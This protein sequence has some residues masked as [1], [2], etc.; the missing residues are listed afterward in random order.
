LH[1]SRSAIVIAS[2][3]EET[4][5]TIISYYRTFT[6]SWNTSFTDHRRPSCLTT[7][8]FLPS[9]KYHPYASRR[10]YSPRQRHPYETIKS[11][12]YYT[13]PLR[14]GK[15]RSPTPHAPSRQPHQ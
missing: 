5:T 2:S 9:I 10:W 1:S 11:Y 3:I 4:S 8:P 12:H 13:L 14:N 15:L 6:L 7:M